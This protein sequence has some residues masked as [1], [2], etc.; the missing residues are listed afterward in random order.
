MPHV[1][2]ADISQDTGLFT[3]TRWT[4]SRLTLLGGVA[5]RLLQDELPETTLATDAVHAQPHLTFPETEG[6]EL[7][8][9]L[10]A[11]RTRHDVFGNGKTAVKVTSAVLAGQALEG[12]MSAESDTRLFAG[13]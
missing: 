13:T 6:L 5:V 10:A 7:E 12:S 11:D 2:K 4:L 8:G 3:Q 1:Q 9:R